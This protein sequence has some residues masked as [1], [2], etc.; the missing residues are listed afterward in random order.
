MYGIETIRKMNEDASKSCAEKTNASALNWGD[1]TKS[2]EERLR[3]GLVE[4][5][6]EYGHDLVAMP[7]L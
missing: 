2:K 5:R 6:R 4:M 3:Q 1:A 7:L